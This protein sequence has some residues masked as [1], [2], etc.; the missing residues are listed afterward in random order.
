[1]S[2][3]RISI[4]TP[5]IA[6]TVLGILDP[7]ANEAASLNRLGRYLQDI[8]SGVRTGKVRVN[9]GAVPAAGT[10][11]FSSFVADDTVTVNGNVLTGKASPSGA[12]QFAVGSTDQDVANNLTAKV[13]ASALA[14]IPGVVAASRRGT[15]L[16]SSFVDA[17][18]VTIN[19][20]IFTGKTSPSE[21]DPLE[22]AIGGSDAITAEYLKAAVERAATLGILGTAALAG[23][24]V[25]RSTAT[26][27]FNFNGTLTLAISA[28]G[29]ATSTTVVFTALAGGQAGNLN[30]LAVSAHGTAVAPV[31]GT[32]GTEFVFGENYAA[33]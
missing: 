30:T 3:Q 24:T 19:G 32:E 26:L 28:H 15:I 5:D 22:F 1:M 13:N 9:V 20:I 33:L 16:L 2:L 21:D 17:D 18:Y 4:D 23:I 29:T 31:G 25:S 6:A 14:K 11:A 10:I 27:T 8:A 12:N 7:K